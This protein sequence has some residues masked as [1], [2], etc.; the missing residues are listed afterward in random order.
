M[1][2]IQLVAAG[3]VGALLATAVVALAQDEEGEAEPTVGDV[4]CA[5]WEVPILGTRGRTPRYDGQSPD[6]SYFLPP[7]WE[8]AGGNVVMATGGISGGGGP[9]TS[10]RSGAAFVVACKHGE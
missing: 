10:A 2:P 4:Q 1:R 7:G 9:R 3:V 5:A 8:P 6:S